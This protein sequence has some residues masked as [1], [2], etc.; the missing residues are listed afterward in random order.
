MLMVIFGAGASYDSIPTYPPNISHIHRMPLANQL[1][2]NRG[3]FADA[4]QRFPKC[5]PIIPY[6]RKPG[7][8]I[9]RE[10]QSLQAEAKEYPERNRQ[11]AAIRYYLQFMLWECEY[12]WNQ[13][14]KGIT[15]QATLLDQIERWRK[16]DEQVCLVTFNYD[17]MLEDALRKT[18]GMKIQTFPDYIGHNHY[19]LFKLHGSVN[20]SREV[21]TSLDNIQSKNGWAIAHE[22]IDRVNEIRVSP[23]YQMVTERPVGANGTTALFP[24]IAIPVEDKLEY[25]CPE[26]HLVMTEK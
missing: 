10:L 8:S 16:A 21:E 23:K 15:N 25:E 1:F 7:I 2:D 11:L 18:I 9:E 17:Q 5:L 6:L 19:K 24:A 22:L 4:M 3:D 13:V 26:E 14:A 12:N 20:W